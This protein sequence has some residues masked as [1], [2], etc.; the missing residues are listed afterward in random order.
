MTRFP[1]RETQE[2]FHSIADKTEYL[3]EFPLRQTQ[4]SQCQIDRFRDVPL[5]FDEGTIQ[6]E[7]QQIDRNFPHEI[8]YL[9]FRSSSCSAA[10]LARLAGSVSLTQASRTKL[11]IR[12]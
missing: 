11:I 6:I 2:L 1:Y 12:F 9:A 10:K 5:R 4:L 8:L 7:D 3:L